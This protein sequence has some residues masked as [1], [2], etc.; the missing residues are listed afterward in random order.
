VGYFD[1]SLDIC[2]DWDLFIRITKY[3]SI[4]TIDEPLVKIGLHNDSLIG[5]KYRRYR[6][7][8][9][10]IT[11]LLHSSLLSREEKKLV[12][13]MLAQMI[14]YR[15]GRYAVRNDRVASGREALLN[16]IKVKPCSF[17]P[18]VYLVLSFL[19][20]RVLTLR[21]WKKW[22]NHHLT[23]YRPLNTGNVNII[24]NERE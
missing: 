24:V 3:F 10:F 21:S 17:K 12:R 23:R 15:F 11:G 22:L 8:A 2:E 13:K 18:Y 1:E 16:C 14:Y 5:N 9:A 7:E 19:G 20:N 4:E 6:G